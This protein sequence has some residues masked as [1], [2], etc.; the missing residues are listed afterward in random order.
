ML[1]LALSCYIQ[2]EW[3]EAGCKVFSFFGDQLIQ[4][5]CEILGVDENKKVKR[6]D[7]NWVGIKLFYEDKLAELDGLMDDTNAKT[8]YDKLICKCAEKVK[9][10]LNRQ[11][12]Q[13][14]FF[15]DETDSETIK[16][17]EHAPLTN[18][19]C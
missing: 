6:D 7:R 16:K 19:E 13:M 9:E 8:N 4:P 10:N 2:S 11:L 14:L 5:L 18:S 12:K 15:R 17:M 3:F 1:F